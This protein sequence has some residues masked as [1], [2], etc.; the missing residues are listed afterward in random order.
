MSFQVCFMYTCT[1]LSALMLYLHPWVGGEIGLIP[2]HVS[3]GRGKYTQNNDASLPLP[4]PSSSNYNSRTKTQTGAAWLLA[5]MTCSLYGLWTVSICKVSN[6]TT[7]ILVI[8]LTAFSSW[9]TIALSDGPSFQYYMH[10]LP[11]KKE[12]ATAAALITGSMFPILQLFRYKLTITL[13]RCFAN[14]DT[15]SVQWEARTYYSKHLKAR[16][17]ICTLNCKCKQLSTPSFFQLFKLQFRIF[18]GFLF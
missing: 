14:F 11:L 7:A 5:W 1:S 10:V 2:G 18:F 9:W 16:Y 4:P 15:D 6:S 13:S 8:C 17:L 12:E 3:M